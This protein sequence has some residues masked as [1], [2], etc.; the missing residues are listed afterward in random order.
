MQNTVTGQRLEKYTEIEQ[1]A[2]FKAPSAILCSNEDVSGKLG[3]DV[4]SLSQSCG[5]CCPKYDMAK[6]RSCQRTTDA[7]IST[8]SV[9]GFISTC[10]N[11]QVC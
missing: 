10:K 2:G 9:S 11:M 7:D 3:C 4:S 8:K 1:T 6:E 5:S